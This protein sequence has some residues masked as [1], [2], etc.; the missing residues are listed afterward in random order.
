MDKDILSLQTDS[1]IYEELAFFSKVLL[2][3]NG[4]DSLTKDEIEDAVDFYKHKAEVLLKE[5]PDKN[6]DDSA[7]K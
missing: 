2:L 7:E 5:T 4:T 3:F 6:T 1:I